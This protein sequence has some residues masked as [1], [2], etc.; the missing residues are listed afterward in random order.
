MDQL[1]PPEGALML[2]DRAQKFPT[3]TIQTYT[4]VYIS[5]LSPSVDEIYLEDIAH[6]LA[7]KVRY[8]GHCRRLYTVGE[9]ILLGDM[10]LKEALASEDLMRAWFL[11]DASEAYLPDVAKP[12]KAFLP[13]FIGIE[14][15]MERVIRQSFNLSPEPSEGIH[16]AV[17][18]VDGYMLHVE[19]EF[20]MHG[21][22]NFEPG[23]PE[24]FP[25]LRDAATRTHQKLASS[26][27]SENPWTEVEAVF[28][29]R[30]KQ[31]GL[32]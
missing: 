15:N 10:I 28:L 24:A 26:L 29:L 17:K 9:H 14:D 27:F 8:T 6:A 13:G 11:H 5:P 31:L 23:P 16:Q 7:M 25:E 30:A 2:L 12:L 4:G 20:L 32:T 3:P 21:T 1:S 19:S 18:W 22:I